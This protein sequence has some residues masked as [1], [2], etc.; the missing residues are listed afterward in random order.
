MSRE[1][2]DGKLECPHCGTV[3]LDLPNDAT[4]DTRIHCSRCG[5]FL[6]TWGE[7]QDV[8]IHSRAIVFDVNR[9]ASSVVNR[10]P[11]TSA[12]L[13]QKLLANLPCPCFR[14]VYAEEEV[15]GPAKSDTD[16]PSPGET[17]YRS[18][19]RHS[20]FFPRPCQISNGG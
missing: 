7:L 20:C 17:P 13:L 9:G 8:F 4:E 1:Y 3:T 10:G 19:H 11:A 12:L 2:L 16:L 15:V 18:H 14:V 6:G 5:H